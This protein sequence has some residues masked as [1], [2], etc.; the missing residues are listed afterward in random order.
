MG[1]LPSGIGRQLP[2]EALS[3]KGS[4]KGASANGPNAATLNITGT[5]SSG[6]KPNWSR[7]PPP[8]GWPITLIGF[9]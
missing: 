9:V 4:T 7:S 5:S 3:S 8:D 6:P 1:D 2:D